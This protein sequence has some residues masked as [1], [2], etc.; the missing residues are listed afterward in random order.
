MTSKIPHRIIPARAG[1]TRE[2]A[3]A[4]VSRWDHPRSRGVY[5]AADRGRPTPM[6]SSPLARGLLAD[7]L[8]LMYDGRIIPARA[9][10]TWPAGGAWRG[11]PDHPRSRGVYDSSEPFS[12][13]LVV[14]VEDDQGGGSYGGDRGGGQADF[15]E[16]FEVF[17]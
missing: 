3:S 15:A 17:E 1:F 4:A 9:G 6:G 11:F 10:F 14:E 12:S 5:E 16:G 7:E 2:P 13:G 8:S